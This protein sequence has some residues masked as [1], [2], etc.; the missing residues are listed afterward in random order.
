MPRKKTLFERL[1]RIPTLT[2][3]EWK[4]REEEVIERMLKFVMTE[5]QEPSSESYFDPLMWTSITYYN[6]CS[7]SHKIARLD[8]CIFMKLVENDQ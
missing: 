8:V 6:V 1:R 7:C 4:K 2:A 3:E 5:P